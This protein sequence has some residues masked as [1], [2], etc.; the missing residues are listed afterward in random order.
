MLIVAWEAS[1]TWVALLFGVGVALALAE[2]FIP[3]HGIL[4]LLSVSSFVAAVAVA[5]L[6][7]QT[8]GIITL[9]ASVLL[10][11][12]LIYAFIRL[13]P[14]TP[15]ARHLILKGPS[16]IGKAGDLVGLKPEDLVGREAVAK[17][18]L[19]PSGKIM[20]D[21]QQ[22]DCLTEGDMVAPGQRVKI[23][24]VHGS[25][26]VVRPTQESEA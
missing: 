9:L 12:F 11:P 15:I 14:Q 18:A 26:V 19:R 20:L 17:T 22:I 3:S 25:K 4:T 8:A 2:I 24:G 21:G 13:W 23:L 6:V 7:G 1:W 10:A 5:F 16:G